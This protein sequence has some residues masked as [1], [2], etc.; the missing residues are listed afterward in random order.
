MYI[1]MYIY[2][3]ICTYSMYIRMYIRTYSVWCMLKETNAHLYRKL[4][5]QAWRGGGKYMV[6]ELGTEGRGGNMEQLYV[7][8][9]FRYCTYVR[10]NQQLGAGGVC[11]L[12]NVS[13]GT[14]MRILG[15][16]LTTFVG[17]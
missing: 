9:L 15:P 16:S 17:L 13:G 10:M 4:A 6:K 12:K 1:C 7:K 11:S 5:V 8:V 3:Y 2:T 14:Y